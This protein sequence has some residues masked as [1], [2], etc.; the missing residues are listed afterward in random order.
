[1]DD[2]AEQIEEA[3]EPDSVPEV[4]GEGQLDELQLVHIPFAIPLRTKKGP[5][6]LGAV[7]AVE[8]QLSALGCQVARVHSDA[9][10]EFSNEQFR[11]RER[12]FHKTNTGGD[13][14]KSNPHAESLIGIMK[15]CA[16]TLMQDAG[17]GQDH[18]PYAI[19]HAARQRFCR[20]VQRVGWKMPLVIPFGA[21]VHVR[22][23]SWSL[24]RGGDWRPRVVK[25]T[26]LAP[27]RELTDGYLVRTVE[28]DLLTTPCVYEHLQHSDP[29][30]WVIPPD[31]AEEGKEVGIPTRRVRVKTPSACVKIL[32]FSPKFLTEDEMAGKLADARRF[33]LDRARDFILGSQWRHSSGRLRGCFE[34]SGGSA[35]VMGF[36]QHG[37]VIGV[38]NEVKDSPGFVRLLT[39]LLGELAPSHVFTTLTLLSETCSEPH[40]DKFNMPSSNL[41]VPLAVPANGRGLWI[42]TAQGN[43]VK[44]VTPKLKVAGRVYPLRVP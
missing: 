4:D 9:G 40:K 42:E 18:W 7:K 21:Q 14:F 1:M 12:G 8:A 41:I 36:F 6:V 16:R 35:R 17:V 43:D 33:D 19:R 30:S 27:A 5:E 2:S 3:V 28:G 22:Q 31:R 38:T 39:R 37:G 26:V 25:A 44:Q 20:L 34:S 11:C 23:R 13:R 29:G 15:G 10:L 24:D 32:A